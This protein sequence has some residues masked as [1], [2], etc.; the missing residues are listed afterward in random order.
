MKEAKKAIYAV[1][2][3]SD[4]TDEELITVVTGAESLFNSRSLTYYPPISQQ[5]KH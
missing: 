4:V 5:I 1:L 2:I 3:S